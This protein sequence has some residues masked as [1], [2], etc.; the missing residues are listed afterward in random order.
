MKRIL[1]VAAVIAVM[2]IFCAGY[3]SAGDVVAVGTQDGTLIGGTTTTGTITG[4]TSDTIVGGFI[5]ELP[6]GNSSTI[7]GGGSINITGGG[8]G[9]LSSIIGPIS[10]C[11]P[12]VIKTHTVNKDGLKIVYT[13]ETY[14]WA[15][16]NN[17][18]SRT[19]TAAV[20]NRKGQLISETGRE[21]QYD[22]NGNP[23]TTDYQRRFN[24]TYEYNKAGQCVE[25]VYKNS[26]YDQKNRYIRTETH[27]MTY[28]YYSDG[29]MKTSQDSFVSMDKNGKVLD[30][31][32]TVTN[33]PDTV[34][35]SSCEVIKGDAGVIERIGVSQAGTIKLPDGV[36]I[37]GTMASKPAL[38]AGPQAVKK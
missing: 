32:C 31:Y 2:S 19:Y 13:C 4:S 1:S 8:T 24:N 14:T 23:E 36:S 38:V 20:Y 22:F 17:R 37:T 25:A 9:V 15:A 34:K 26:F 12:P 3:A 33:Y 35:A 16:N 28:T 5:G 29:T 27:D 21:Y 18:A 11:N 10:L 7:I 6:I 30:T